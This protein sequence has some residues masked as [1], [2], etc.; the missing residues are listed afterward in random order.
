[1]PKI[2]ADT[3]AAHVAQQ[4]A[5]VV[6]AAAAL[7]AERG[8]ANVSM[9]DIAE[10]VG[11]AR[12]SLYRYFPDKGHILAAWLTSEIDPLVAESMLIAGSDNSA[13]ERLDR[14]LSFHLALGTNHEHRLMER[15]AEEIGSLSAEV[16]AEIGDQHRRLYGTIEPVLRELLAPSDR[17]IPIVAGL[18]GG[19]LRS[20]SEL[21]NR[22]VPISLV[23]PELL[24]CAAA[25]VTNG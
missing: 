8:I 20:A 12:N 3:V 17:S 19:T 6:D 1:M 24:R 11:L 18:I 13:S 25:L 9:S 21:V 10:A 7:F 5:A 14:W 23:E 4:R 2:S 22:G 15:V 16:R